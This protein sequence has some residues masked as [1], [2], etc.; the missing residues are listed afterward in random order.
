[1][2][3][4]K[5][6]FDKMKKRDSIS[7]VNI[8]SKP[9][10]I[11]LSSGNYVVNKTISGSFNRG[12][13]V[14]RLAMITGPSDAGKSFLAMSAAVQAQKAGYGVFIIDSER[15]IDDAYM[16]AVGVDVNNELL[17]YNS[18]D[19]LEAATKLVS[20]FLQSYRENKEDLPPFLLL[21]DSLDELKTKAHIE[22]KEKGVVHNDQGQ[23]AKQLK[24]FV[25]NIMHDI[26][27][28]DIFAV[29]TKQP[30]TNQDPIMSKVEPYI[31]TPAMRFPFSQI[32][33]LTNRRLKDAKTKKIEGIHLNVDAY[34][35]RFCKPR[36]KVSIEI[37]YDKGIDPFSGLLA[38]AESMGIVKKSGAWYK[39]EDNNIQASNASEE[40]LQKILNKM[41]ENDDDVFLDVLEDDEDE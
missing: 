8:Y 12:Y 22:K 32:L 40:V 18:V 16:E 33:L 34:K 39:F 4:A 35:T 29:C 25:S 1:M 7:G 5:S 20:E 13:A 11:W 27:G 24:Q 2:T 28:L 37:P 21:I 6:F 9:P 17:F 26:G 3:K 41:I 36:Q 38:A 19:S 14:G 15:A 30:Y 23:H 10:H 31:I